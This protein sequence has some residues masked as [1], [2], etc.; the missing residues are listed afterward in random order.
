MVRA[1][2]NG[3]V[4]ELRAKSRLPLRNELRGPHG[5]SATT[6]RCPALPRIRRSPRRSRGNEAR[7]DEARH[8]TG[9]RAPDAEPQRHDLIPEAAVDLHPGPRD[10]PSVDGPMEIDAARRTHAKLG[11]APVP[12]LLGDPG[13][14]GA[15]RDEALWSRKR[16]EFGAETAP[17]PRAD[18]GAA[19]ADHQEGRRPA[20]AGRGRAASTARCPTVA[21]SRVPSAD[22]GRSRPRNAVRG[23][24]SSG[25][26]RPRSGDRAA[27]SRAGT[28][29][30]PGGSASSAHRAATARGSPSLRTNRRRR[31]AAP[32]RHRRADP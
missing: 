27:R 29:P 16:L 13:A 8:G 31:G 26:R 17:G 1:Q 32:A 25:A 2:A 28:R 3:R 21:E 12:R 11:A 22:S 4:S 9:D 10:P 7:A 19:F 14:L 20:A 6:S 30:R 15:M 23:R 24:G 18:E 5:R